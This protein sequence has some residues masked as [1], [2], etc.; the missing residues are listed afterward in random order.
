MTVEVETARVSYTGAGTTGPFTIP[1]YF[2]ANADI[3][4]IKVTIADGTED[5][6]TLTTD[7]TLT[8]AGDEAGGE[9]TLVASLSSSYKLVI[10][11]D[12]DVLQETDYPANDAFPSESNEQAVDRLTM[13]AQ[14]H[15]SLI[16]RAVR[17]PDGDTTGT[18]M[19]LPAAVSRA[20]KALIFDASGNATV[21]DPASAVTSAENVTFLPSGSGAVS[22]T[23]QAKGRDV[24]SVLD[25]GAVLDNSTDDA[26]A[27]TLALATGKKV[28]VP[29]TSTG[30][31]LASGIE[32]PAGVEL[33]CDHGMSLKPSVDMTY[34][35]KVHAGGWFEGKVDS[36]AITFTGV[37][38]DYDGDDNDDAVP[39][40]LHTK[41]GARVVHVL[42]N[43]AGTGTAVKL[44]ADG[45]ANAR[46]MGVDH[47]GVVTGGEYGCWM[48][49]TSTDSTKFITGCRVTLYG[50]ETLR[51]LYMESSN[52]NGYDIDG[53]TI[54]I[55]AQPRSGTTVPAF[56]VCGQLNTFDLLPWDWSGVVG[57]SPYAL[58]IAAN[59]RW[60]TIIWRTLRAYIDNDSTDDDN[61]FFIPSDDG[62]ITLSSIRSLRSGGV[63]KLPGSTVEVENNVYYKALLAGG[64]S[65]NILGFTTSDDLLIQGSAVAGDN[66][67]YDAPN[68]TGL[69]IFRINS[70]NVAF[71][72]ASV[73][74]QIQS[75]RL[76]G[77][78]GAAVTA[79]NNLVLGTDGSRFQ[80]AGATQIN[81]IA[82]SNWQGGAIVTLHFQSTPTVKHDQAASSP[83]MPIMLAGAVDF[84]ASANDQL[85]LQYDSTDSKWYEIARTVI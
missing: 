46:I 67:I 39:F 32:V 85:T 60:N 42:A 10:F 31:K 12:P 44:H 74:Y 23:M 50:S 30:A 45:V 21:G 25:F 64:T 19:V 41:T 5:E 66:V 16:E 59:A 54:T 35:V 11:R 20:S 65:R 63:I 2:L 8:G 81:L 75:K 53:N 22:R 61:I 7:F 84:V 77:A 62:G 51:P 76:Q 52:A 17:L 37:Q 9:L 80:I 36:S 38:V 71:L 79:A 24:V 55:N 13:I 27:F 56:T 69:H 1:F 68:S 48:R 58:N 29:Y 18:D 15:K 72:G 4:A 34:V 14:R 73:G 82:N 49:Q 70:G 47:E 28:T 6:L 83:N 3:R 40:R 57:T 33:I 43:G 78:Q 26:A